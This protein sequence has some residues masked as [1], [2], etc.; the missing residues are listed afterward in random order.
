MLLS[1]DFHLS[2]SLI[3]ASEGLFTSSIISAIVSSTSSTMLAFHF[4]S[5]E[6]LSHFENIIA[7]SPVCILD[8]AIL[9][10]LAGLTM[11]YIQRVSSWQQALMIGQ[12]SFLVTGLASLAFWMAVHWNSLTKRKISGNVEALTQ[13]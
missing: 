11:W 5:Q 3:K 6:S 12:V 9:E 10:A 8:V 1:K 7:L 13:E 2:N 4:S